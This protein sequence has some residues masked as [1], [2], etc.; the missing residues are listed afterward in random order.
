MP[1]WSWIL[2][3]IAV[4]AVLGIV[5]WLVWSR[6]RTHG[7]RDQFG[8]EYDRVVD[9]APN[10]RRGE[11][12]LDARQKRREEIDI[13]QLSPGARERYASEWTDTQARFVDA[14]GDAVREADRLVS[15]VMA[16][17]G[18][19]M[20]RFDQR[21]ADISVDHPDVVQDYRAA[22][23]IS[24]ANEEGRAST[25]DLR[26]AMVHYRSLFESLLEDEAAGQEVRP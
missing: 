25:E 4:L 3:A 16:G 22:H 11:S 12:E 14:P 24:M 21:A 2:I 19:P 13:R 9:E 18:Y 6:R 5:A 23:G 26:Q 7:L 1:A 17:R 10:R 8:P 20:E 15:A